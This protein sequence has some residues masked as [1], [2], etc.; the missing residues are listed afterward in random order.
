M[1]EPS[2]VLQWW[3][4]DQAWEKKNRLSGSAVDPV[5]S[6]CPVDAQRLSTR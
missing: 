3:C 6:A 1:S 2:G 4:H 5:V